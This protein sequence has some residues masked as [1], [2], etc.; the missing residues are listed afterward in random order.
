LSLQKEATFYMTGTNLF[1][2][3]G[4]SGYD[5]ETMLLSDPY[6]MGIDFGK[7]PHVRS[8]IIGVQLSL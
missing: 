6:L 3:T 7:V 8:I 2:L 1:T 5:P 4:Y